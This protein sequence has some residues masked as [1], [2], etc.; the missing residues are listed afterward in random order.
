MAEASSCMLFG[1]LTWTLFYSISGERLQRVACDIKAGGLVQHTHQHM[2]AHMLKHESIPASGLI[3]ADTL[4][5][6]AA[7]LL[8]QISR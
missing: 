2:P 4:K 7:C 8:M 5:P 1:D 3:G 6:L